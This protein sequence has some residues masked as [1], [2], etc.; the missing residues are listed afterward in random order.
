M[1][2]PT[3]KTESRNRRVEGDTH[4]AIASTTSSPTPTGYYNPISRDRGKIRKG[5]SRRSSSSAFFKPAAAL[6]SSSIILVLLYSSINNRHSWRTRGSWISSEGNI[7]YSRCDAAAH[8]TT[9]CLYSIR[10]QLT[11]GRS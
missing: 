3:V 8:Q 1:H 11:V 6:L 9:V 5:N 10:Q 4:T 7:D 2:R